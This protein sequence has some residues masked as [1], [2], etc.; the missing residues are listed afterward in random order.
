MVCDFDLKKS[1]KDWRIC[2]LVIILKREKSLVKKLRA[3]ERKFFCLR[4]NTPVANCQL[5]EAKFLQKYFLNN[6]AR[7][8]ITE[9]EVS[10]LFEQNIFPALFVIRSNP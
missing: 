7:G 10:T 8:T 5:R 6:F 9:S 4:A 2:E 3:G 1:R